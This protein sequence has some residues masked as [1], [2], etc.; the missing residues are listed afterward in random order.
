MLS[1][2][3]V[4]AGTYRIECLLGQGGMAHVFL[5]SHTRVEGKKFALK[6][7]SNPAASATFLQRFKREADVL[8]KLSHAH[9]V[10]I[11]DFNQTP[12]GMP[13]L[14][15]EFLEGEDLSHFLG[16]TGALQ[17]DVALSIVYQVGQALQ[18]AHDAG[19]IHR[20]LK[21]GNLFICKNGAFPNYIKVLDF[22]I[23]RV[24]SDN[25]LTSDR[26]LMGTPSYMSPEQARG[27]VRQLDHRSDQFSLAVILYELL[28]GRN[29][30]CPS[31]EAEPLAI[32]AH[33]VSSEPAPLPFPTVW[34]A[35]QRALRKNPQDRFPSIY[36][37]VEALGARKAFGAMAKPV[38]MGTNTNG[39]VG[40]S[41]SGSRTLRTVM[42]AGGVVSALV[43]GSL[44][45]L[46]FLQPT[47]RPAPPVPITIRPAVL[48]PAP[49]PIEP[50]APGN[51]SEPAMPKPV[52]EAAAV[53]RL[54][55]TQ[56]NHTEG[57]GINKSESPAEDVK[58]VAP[59][60]QKPAAARRPSATT[61]SLEAKARQGEQPKST[62][63][64]TTPSVASSGFSVSISNA[65]S[66]QSSIIKECASKELKDLTG[67]PK[68]YKITLQRSGALHIMDSPQ[69]I[70]S[71][72]LEKCLRSRFQGHIV[73]ESVVL[74]VRGSR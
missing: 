16:R 20:D 5:V 13:Y 58:T 10:N 63:N 72:E 25:G 52:E 12:D 30:F 66:E 32:L 57:S 2:G 49:K 31:P 19:I 27:M 60:K 24:L 53:A 56:S 46:R 68:T 17:K 4:V 47:P 65:N 61:E 14:V 3:D 45:V 70:Y 51:V 37:F 38:T 43:V 1:V 48:A 29:P 36:A 11:I 35:L 34:P 22:G 44:V 59:V 33:V 62:S 55:K 73:P 71:T 7:I 18:A 40:P 64:S 9:I 23:A 67:M 15:M 26:S 41:S 6:L 69:E 28:S 21:P 74:T 42:R 39:E 8:G 54:T 50:S